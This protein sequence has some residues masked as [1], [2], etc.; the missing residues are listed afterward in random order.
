ME[1]PARES[2]QAYLALSAIV[3]G[4]AVAF[5]TLPI[6]VVA[7]LAPFGLVGVICTLAVGY[8]RAEEAQKRSKMERGEGI[9]AQWNLDAAHWQEFERLNKGVIVIP[10]I[11]AERLEPSS[12]GVKV[13]FAEDAVYV[14]GDCYTMDRT[15]TTTAML[16]PSYIELAQSGLEYHTPICVPIPADFHGDAER[17]AHYFN[18]SPERS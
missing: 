3:I 7:V 14:D 9:V 11:A 16:N 17:V 1:N 4:F 2:R 6:T 13:V 18:S 5:V 8:I 12:S 15:W 10:R